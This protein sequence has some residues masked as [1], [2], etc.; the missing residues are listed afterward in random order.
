M[1]KQ[2]DPECDCCQG[3]NS[4]A[5]RA[6]IESHIDQYGYSVM[7]VYGEFSYSI[8]GV[9][10]GY[11][12]FVLGFNQQNLINYIFPVATGN[13]TYNEKL[14]AGR[15]VKLSAE[16]L[17]ISVDCWLI[18]VPATHEIRG[19]FIRTMRSEVEPNYVHIVFPDADGLY[20]WETGYTEFGQKL[21]IE[22]EFCKEQVGIAR[23]H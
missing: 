12:D 9:A 5:I 19:N 18:P 8:G 11:P 1:S 15:A 2:H 3:L 16:E 4:D 7:S 21:L 22:T 13:Q 14:L 17:G 10:S 23:A 20:P 6:Q